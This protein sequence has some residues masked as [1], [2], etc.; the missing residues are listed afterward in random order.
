MSG[1]AADGA[2]GSINIDAAQNDSGNAAIDIGL[3]G[4]SK[5]EIYDQNVVFFW[6]YCNYI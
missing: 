1:T 5:A 4:R 2:N 3:Q 6:R